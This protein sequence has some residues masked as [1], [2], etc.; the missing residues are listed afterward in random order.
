M[1][2]AQVAQHHK[3]KAERMQRE[4]KE[5]VSSS[6][7]SGT[8]SA[9]SRVSA[10]SHSE[11]RGTHLIALTAPRRGVRSR[12]LTARFVSERDFRD[13]PARYSGR[14]PNSSN[15][16]GSGNARQESGGAPRGGFRRRDGPVRFREGRG[17]GRA[18]GRE[19]EGRDGR[20]S[21]ET[22]RSPK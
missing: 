8:A 20:D 21:R 4:E 14:G 7:S 10:Q 18:E 16:N 17:E 1:S 22:V 5:A 13:G 15:G 6:G 12:L 19:R 9:A 11:S 2:Y 3:E